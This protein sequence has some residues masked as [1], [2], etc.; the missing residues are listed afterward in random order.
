MHGFSNTLS[1]ANIDRTLAEY[2]TSVESLGETISRLRGFRLFEALKRDVLGSG[3]YPK[4]T[5]F[6][7][8]NRIMTDLV[9]LYGVRWL[10]KHEVFPFDTYSVEY[11]N[12][13]TQGFDIRASSNRST[14]IGE[15]F[16][17][18]PSFFQS[19][20]SSMLKKL[21]QSTARADFKIVMFNHD[22]V[23]TQYLPA[24]AEGEFFV[25]VRVGTDEARV[26]PTPALQPTA[27]STVASRG[28]TSGEGR[29]G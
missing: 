3:P 23:R 2:V 18:A 26:E 9:I 28:S 11:G 1:K 17:V 8:A 22:A 6:E 5:L 25:M 13:D 12:D 24:T 29:D 19:K 27:A 10:L 14:L 7:A 21:R 16:N 15:A 4:V 20:K